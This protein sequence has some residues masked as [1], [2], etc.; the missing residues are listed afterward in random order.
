[1]LL[2]LKYIF[3]LCIAIVLLQTHYVFAD[4][5]GALANKAKIEAYSK[6]L[7]NQIN[8]K[9]VQK[10]K[11]EVFKAAHYGYL[12]LAEQGK[13]KN[14]RYLTICDF[15]LSSNVNRLW[16]IDLYEKKVVINTLVA[17]GQNTGD[18]FATRFSNIE[19]SHQ[20]SLGFYVTSNSYTGEKGYAMKLLG[21]DAGFNDRAFSRD[22]VMH[23]A[24]YVSREFARANKRLGRSWGCPSVSFEVV[25]PIINRIK[26]GSC[27]YIYHPQVTYHK[28]SYWLNTPIM[29]LP[30]EVKN[31][32]LDKSDFPADSNIISDTSMVDVEEEIYDREGFIVNKNNELVK[33]EFV[34]PIDINELKKDET[35]KVQEII[36]DEKDLTPAMKEKIKKR[37]QIVKKVSQI[38][39]H[40]KKTTKDSD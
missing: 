40:S 36:I 17:H 27:L 2:K 9:G 18:E 30:K 19:D 39:D 13:I 22:I 28:S 23:G 14:K 31:F 24:D 12:K 5:F 11:F 3:L 1:M 32:V 7:Y 38:I 21:M 37:T 4:N 10:L 34:E 33:V 16:L 29:R 25:N 26:N 35:I 8:F 15:S 20:S 6:E